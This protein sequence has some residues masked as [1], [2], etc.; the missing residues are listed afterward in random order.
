M[1]QGEAWLNLR[2]TRAGL[3]ATMT[4]GGTSRVT[5][6]P[7]P[8]TARAPMVMP[9]RSVAPEPI[10]APRW[11]RVGS[12]GQSALQFALAAGRSRVTIIGEGDVVADENFVLQ[13]HPF[14]DKCVTGYFTAGADANA[15]LNLDKSSDFAIV[16]NLTSVKVGKAVDADATAQ[17]DVRSNLP[18]WLRLRLDA[19]HMNATTSRVIRSGSR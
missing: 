13:H 10:E 3:P 5:T 7:A 9:Q 18:E 19:C 2:K 16:A 6:L 17:F 12:H 14:A 15:F 1:D 11:T 8:I 4:S